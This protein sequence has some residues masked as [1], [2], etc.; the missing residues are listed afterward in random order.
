M[1]S[2]KISSIPSKEIVKGIIIK[3]ERRSKFGDFPQGALK[4]MDIF[5]LPYTTPTRAA[6]V[7]INQV[8]SHLIIQQDIVGIQIRVIDAGIMETPHAGAYSRPYLGRKRGLFQQCGKV[9]GRGNSLGD[10]IAPIISE[11]SG[12]ERGDRARYREAPTI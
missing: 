12:H 5:S 7:K 4:P 2:L 8:N 3:I 11:F 9:L 10:E 6:T 1:A